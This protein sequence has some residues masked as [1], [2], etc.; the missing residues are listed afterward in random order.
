MSN[1]PRRRINAGHGML[2]RNHEKVETITTRLAEFGMSSNPP[3]SICSRVEMQNSIIYTIKNG[4]FTGNM[5]RQLDEIFPG[6]SY[7]GTESK[8]EIYI[9]EDMHSAQDGPSFG[10]KIDSAITVAGGVVLFACA[11]ALSYS[12]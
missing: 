6:A 9:N 10:Q 3:F 12:G 1:T 7:N 5:L 8:I 2:G 4:H 11:A